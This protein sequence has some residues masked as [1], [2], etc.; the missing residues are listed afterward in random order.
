MDPESGRL[1]HLETVSTVPND[2]ADVS[3][4][5]EIAMHPSGR[6]L[7]VTNRAL[8]ETGCCSVAVCAV[9]SARSTLPT[10]IALMGAYRLHLTLWCCHQ[11]E[12]GRVSLSDIAIIDDVP[13][14][15]SPQHIALDS[16]GQHFYV[17][18][19]MSLLQFFVDVNHG[20]LVRVNTYPC[21]GSDGD[22]VGGI[23]IIDLA[24]AQL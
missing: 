12:A 22:Q 10:E 4:C 24:G 21:R 18:D 16:S 1:T 2:F 13:P 17:G 8:P 15:F 20:R 7:F 3:H 6:W 11:N 23:R 19:G 14:G 9:V 5:A